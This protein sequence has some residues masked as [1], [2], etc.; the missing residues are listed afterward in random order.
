MTSSSGSEDGSLAC[1]DTVCNVKA[2]SLSHKIL[3]LLDKTSNLHFACHAGGYC[4]LPVYVCPL[5]LPFI[6]L[7]NSLRN[8]KYYRLYK[9]I[10]KK[11][12]IFYVCKVSVLKDQDIF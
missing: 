8:R 6:P 10:D 7:V 9:Q 3:D 11:I 2:L 4:I 5:V 12:L 1:F